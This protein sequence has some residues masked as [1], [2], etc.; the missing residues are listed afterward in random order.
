MPKSVLV[1]DNKIYLESISARLDGLILS[2][3]DRCMRKS[4]K[5]NLSINEMQKFI[6]NEFMINSI[7]K[8]LSS[9]TCLKNANCYNKK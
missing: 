6:D 5:S 9:I 8:A 2:D 7:D 1:I 3:T 4:I